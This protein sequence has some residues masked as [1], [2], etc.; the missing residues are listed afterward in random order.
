MSSTHD[1]EVGNDYFV[2]QSVSFHKLP[3]RV[4]DQLYNF[5]LWW[6][7]VMFLDQFVCI[8]LVVAMNWNVNL[9]LTQETKFMSF[10]ETVDFSLL[11]SLFC[12]SLWIELCHSEICLFE[13]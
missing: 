13:L 2:W 1:T 9:C 6:W 12:Y 8:V 7:S 4:K 5:E 11:K 10:F 3:L